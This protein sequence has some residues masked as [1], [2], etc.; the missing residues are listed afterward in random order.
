MFIQPTLDEVLRNKQCGINT[1]DGFEMMFA[2]MIGSS[3]E[4]LDPCPMSCKMP[5]SNTT[6]QTSMRGN[7]DD[8]IGHVGRKAFE[9]PVFRLYSSGGLCRW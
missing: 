9:A 5:H 8:A 6:R 1:S 2:V 4:L 3:L 7:E